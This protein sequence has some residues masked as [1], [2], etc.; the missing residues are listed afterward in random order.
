MKDLYLGEINAGDCYELWD[1]NVVYVHAVGE[2]Y[3]ECYARE[4]AK[5]THWYWCLY[6]RIQFRALVRTILIMEV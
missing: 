2:K 3:I 6:T 4:R 1:G 5:T